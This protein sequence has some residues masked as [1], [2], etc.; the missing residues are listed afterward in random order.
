[1]SKIESKLHFTKV[2]DPRVLRY[3]VD[4][5]IKMEKEILSVCREGALMHMLWDFDILKLKEKK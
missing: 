5:N 1:M 4:E 2:R 3:C